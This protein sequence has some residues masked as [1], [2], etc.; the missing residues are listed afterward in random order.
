MK[1]IHGKRAGALLL[2]GVLAA[3]LLLGGCGKKAPL[4]S[5]GNPVNL[6]VWHYYNGP[7]MAAFDALAEEFNSTVG[8]RK[9][10]S[11]LQQGLRHRPGN[12]S[13]QLSE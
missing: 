5:P 13:L 9:R 12:G 4:Y 1:G 6:T 8:T 7:Q 3:G 10:A 2:A 11:G